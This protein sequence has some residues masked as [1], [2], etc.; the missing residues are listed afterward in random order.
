MCKK[1]QKDG[2]FD[3]L[4]TAWTKAL[5]KVCAIVINDIPQD[6]KATGGESINKPLYR[7]LNNVFRNG[8][9]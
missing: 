5:H 6:Y 4:L 7:T 3:R 2:K 8:T 9:C 1:C